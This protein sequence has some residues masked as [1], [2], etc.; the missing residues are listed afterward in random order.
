MH[1]RRVIMW[2]PCR[3]DDPPA[4]CSTGEAGNSTRFLTFPAGVY[5]CDSSTLHMR[6]VPGKNRRFETA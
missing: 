5:A 3:T 1:L 4:A 6:G 2:G